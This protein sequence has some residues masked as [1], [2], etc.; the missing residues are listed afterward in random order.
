MIQ[1]LSVVVQVPFPGGHSGLRIWH[2]HSSGTV[3]TPVAVSVGVRSLAPKLPY[4]T[5][6]A[7]TN[8]KQKTENKP[9]LSSQMDD[10]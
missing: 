6:A 10:T 1:L 5:G 3:T 2:C 8:N 4:A 7:K 9:K